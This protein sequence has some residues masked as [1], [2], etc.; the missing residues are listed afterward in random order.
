MRRTENNGER[1]CGHPP[2]NRSLVSDNC[3][4]L[5]LLS[6]LMMKERNIVL[7]MSAILS[8]SC[9]HAPCNEVEERNGV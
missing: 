9:Y 8:S 5:N 1:D 6:P 2:K 3:L 4:L 7:C